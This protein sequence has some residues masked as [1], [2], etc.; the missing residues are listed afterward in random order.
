VA[1]PIAVFG[2]LAGIAQFGFHSMP[3]PLMGLFAVLHGR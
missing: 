1:V 3:T 2:L